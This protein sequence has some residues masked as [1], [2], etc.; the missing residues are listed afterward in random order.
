MA[1][2]RWVEERGMHMVRVGNSDIVLAE[3][4]RS[5]TGFWWAVYV[6]AW[7]DAH[8]Q[9]RKSADEIS[10]VAPTLTGAKQAASVALSLVERLR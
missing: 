6:A 3:A 7:C 9:K 10:G 4:W 2:N 8:G 1:K 5:H